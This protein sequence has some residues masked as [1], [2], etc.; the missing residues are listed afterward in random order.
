MAGVLSGIVSLVRTYADEPQQV[1]GRVKFTN[2]AIMELAEAAWPEVVAEVW[3]LGDDKVRVRH[4]VSIVANTHEYALPPYIGQIYS[5]EHYSNATAVANSQL[6]W[7]IEPR[8]FLNPYGPGWMIEGPMLYM[9]P[10]FPADTVVRLTYT[11]NGEVLAH[12]GVGTMVATANSTDVTGVTSVVL[13]NSPTL[14]SLDGRKEAYAGCILRVLNT[15]GGWE[16]ADPAIVQE[17]VIKTYDFTTRTATFA[18]SLNPL[19]AYT[20]TTLNNVN[21]TYEVIPLHMG[22]CKDVLSLKVARK[23]FNVIGDGTRARSAHFEYLDA[24]RTLKLGSSKKQARRKD[25]FVRNVRGRRRT[26]MTR[27]GS[28]AIGTI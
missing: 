19:P 15:V 5:V 7:E 14:G 10:R 17:R 4:D 13:S 12:E 26:G 2:A 24:L 3:A 21:C 1:G 9:D 25:Q 28:A 22:L 18:P 8:S 11:P 23:I 27:L 20:G 16:D 6:L